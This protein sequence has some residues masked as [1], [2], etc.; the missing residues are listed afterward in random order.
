MGVTTQR[1]GLLALPTNSG[2]FT[3]DRFA[4]VPEGSVGVGVQATE[5]VRVSL[6]YTVLYWSN[7][8]RPGDQIDRVVN[9]AALPV[10]GGPGPG[11]GPARPAFGFKD[12]DFWAQ[13]LTLGVEFRF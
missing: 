12:T 9:P 4:V 1:G 13:G 11:T 3:R 10:N 7:A 2:H 6:A 8:A 5:R